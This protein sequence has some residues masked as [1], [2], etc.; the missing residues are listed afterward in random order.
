MQPMHYQDSPLTLMFE[1]GKHSFFLLMIC[2][3][4][5]HHEQ[6]VSP[7]YPSTCVLENILVSASAICAAP[8]AVAHTMFAFVKRLHSA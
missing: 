1:P 8:H 6:F 7:D 5:Q 4:R 2:K 3:S